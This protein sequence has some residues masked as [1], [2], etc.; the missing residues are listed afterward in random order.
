LAAFSLFLAA[1][2]PDLGSI[3]ESEG[4]FRFVEVLEAFLEAP[5]EES[6]MCNCFAALLV[7]GML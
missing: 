1:F 5:L 6:S 4:A 3:S 2:L 7:V